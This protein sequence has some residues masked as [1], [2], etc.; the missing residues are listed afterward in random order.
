MRWSL[1]RLHNL[2]RAPPSTGTG[3]TLAPSH[4]HRMTDTY[5]LTCTDCS[6]ERVVEGVERSLDVSEAHEGRYEDGHFVDMV[7]VEGD[8]VPD[9]DG[10]VSSS[11]EAVSSSDSTDEEQQRVSVDPDWVRTPPA[12]CALP[13]TSTPIAVSRGL[14]SHHRNRSGLPNA[15]EAVGARTERPGEGW[16]RT[17][18]AESPVATSTSTAFGSYAFAA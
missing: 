6:F 15:V 2:P 9:G 17:A 5:H 10:A 1:P 18:Y 12:A 8:D 14:G 11:A 7:L 13:S 3:S 16:A 4:T